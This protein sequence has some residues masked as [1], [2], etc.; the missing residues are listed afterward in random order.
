MFYQI[1]MEDCLIQKNI[2]THVYPNSNYEQTRILGIQ[3]Q[4]GEKSTEVTMAKF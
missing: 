4:R 3:H 1:F 2:M